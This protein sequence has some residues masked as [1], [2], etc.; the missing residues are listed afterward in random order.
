LLRQKEGTKKMR[1][2]GA[3]KIPQEACV[4]VLRAED[5]G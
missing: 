3:V 5:E 4:S 1:M 2:V